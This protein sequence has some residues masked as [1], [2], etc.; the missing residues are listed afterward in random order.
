M[1]DEK[2][3]QP[4]REVME[5]LLKHY[6]LGQH[7]N[8]ARLKAAWEK[9]MGEFV[10]TRTESLRVK[11][12]TLFLGMNS[13]PLRHEI[14]LSKSEVIGRLNEYMGFEMIEEIVIM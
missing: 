7:Y 13:A 8:E 2:A 5:K 6:R 3:P 12:K 9:L 11:D 14:L 10:S 1:P 4:L